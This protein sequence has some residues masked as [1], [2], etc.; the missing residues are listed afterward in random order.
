MDNFK[1]G[2]SKVLAS[3][4]RGLNWL[5]SRVLPQRRLKN[6]A[7]GLVAVVFV[8]SDI[9]QRAGAWVRRKLGIGRHQ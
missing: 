1:R 4:F 3:L 8:A 6:L 7:F 2:E 9:V 5:A